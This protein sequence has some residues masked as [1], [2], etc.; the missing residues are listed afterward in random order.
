MITHF[1]IKDG[2]NP[3]QEQLDSIKA[4]RDED[5]VFDSDC[6]EMTPRMRKAYRCAIAQRN[7]SRAKKIAN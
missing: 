1:T 2:Q 7:R 4:I 3:T 6:P 5:I